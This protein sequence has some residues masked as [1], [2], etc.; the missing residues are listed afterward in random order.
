MAVQVWAT[1]NI[2]I[3]IFS[4][5]H[6]VDL[7]ETKEFPKHVLGDDVTDDEDYRGFSGI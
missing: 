5:F 6:I 2:V 3:I 1:P 7:P 4:G